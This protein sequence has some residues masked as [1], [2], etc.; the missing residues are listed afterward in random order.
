MSNT[1]FQ[2]P[3]LSE[4]ALT[5]TGSDNFNTWLIGVRPRYHL[6]PV[7]KFGFFSALLGLL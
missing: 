6:Q 4:L 3:S 1:G 2:E 5:L 7:L